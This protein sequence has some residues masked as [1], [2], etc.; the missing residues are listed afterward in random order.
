MRTALDHLPPH[1]QRELERVVKIIFEEF[2]DGVALATKDW[3]KRGRIDKIILYGSYARG[4]WVDEPYT[5]KGYRSDFDVMIIVSDQR[6]SEM[7]EVWAKLDERLMREY[8][9]TQTLKTPVN[10]IVHTM[11]DMNDGLAH[12]RYFFMDVALDGIA[13][14]QMEDSEFHKPRPKSPAQAFEMSKEYFDDWFPSAMKRFDGAKYYLSQG[15]LRDAAFDLHQ[16]VERLYHGI[17]LVKTFYTP[18]VHK[19]AFLRTQAERLDLRLVEAWPRETRAE[20]AYFQKLKDAYVKGRYSKH[21]EVT[22]E[23]IDWLVERIEILGQAVLAVCTE[24][25]AKLRSE[26]EAGQ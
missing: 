23:E 22:R 5:A 15:H 17:L 13:L 14:Y 11:S 12:G 10:F 19:L 21:Y 2:S 6:L 8:D 4:G 18:H 9:I 3:K 20:R 16:A 26:A 24:H 1:K 25:L 7:A